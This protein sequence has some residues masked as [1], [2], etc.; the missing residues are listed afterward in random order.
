MALLGGKGLTFAIQANALKRS[1]G[2]HSLEK[3]LNSR[4]S[5]WKALEFSSALNV[6]AWKVFFDAFW[7]SKTM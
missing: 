4:E 3:S 6:V 7:L 2:S 5:F 1:Q